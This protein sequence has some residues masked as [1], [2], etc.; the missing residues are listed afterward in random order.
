MR[1][2]RGEGWLL[3]IVLAASLATACSLPVRALAAEPGGQAAVPLPDPD[4]PSATTIRLAPFLTVGGK[5]KLE[6]ERKENFD[7]DDARAD[8]LS[9]LEP[10]LRLAFSFD[11]TRM[12]Q[13]FLEM[14][15]K[16]KF[17]LEEE[18]KKKTRRTELELKEA[19]ISF[20]EVMDGLSFRI[21]R[22]LFR[23]GRRWL[24][25]EELDAARVFYRTSTLS[26]DLS[27]SRKELV[28]RDLLNSDRKE[29]IN[30]YLLYGRYAVSKGVGIAAYG[31]VRDDR[32]A[33][34][35]SPI[36]F[37]LHSRGEIV[38]ALDY[39]LEL[40]HVRGREGSRRIR[41]TGFDLGATYKAALP[42]EPSLT[43]GYAFGTGDADPNGRVDRSF[44][45]TG[46]QGN[47]ARF[48]GVTRF[49]VYGE[50]FDPELSNLSVFTGGIGLRPSRRS[51][52]DLVYHRYLQDEAST[53]IRDSAIRATPT[54]LSRK[55]GSE[56]DLIAGY[57]EI[58]NVDV[59]LVLGYFVPGEAF[60]ADA[61][62]AFFANVEIQFRF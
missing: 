11:P 7:L 58:R 13:T 40:A 5:V 46:L 21:G 55:L 36:F 9:T 31:F 15:L 1:S 10:E 24:Y 44:R 42:L 57:R 4:V 32:S 45:Q 49:K 2:S 50:L 8:D 53:R 28:D 39:W 26:L 37:G 27:A 48:N 12:L 61:D 22:Q 20:K 19:F 6:Y 47:K 60:P 17:A 30:N 25:D 62:N 35:D 23:D 59:S 52:L 29:R 33:E 43:V 18:G 54:G 14:E 41:G 51:S 16:K 38:R 56:L 34:R 3:R